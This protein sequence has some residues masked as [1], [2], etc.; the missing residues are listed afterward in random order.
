M[1][2]RP[3]GPFD[4]YVHRSRIKAFLRFVVAAATVSVGIY[5]I[6]H[7][8]T[9]IVAQPPAAPVVMAPAPPPQV[10]VTRRVVN[11]ETHETRTIYRCIVDGETTYSNEPCPRA[12]VVDTRPAVG[13]YAPTPVQRQVVQPVEVAAAPARRPTAEDAQA[14][15][16]ARCKWLAAAIDSIDAQARQALHF[17]E[18]D[19]LRERRRA[20][21]DEQ[22]ELRC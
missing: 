18:Q 5:A 15:R 13:S 3:V 11:V 19:R 12:R 10:T 14:K 8:A 22:F 9:P 2:R 1:P 4:A 21:V 17:S 6:L 20:L 16:D 7:K